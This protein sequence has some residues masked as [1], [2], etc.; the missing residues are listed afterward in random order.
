[1]SMLIGT[2]SIRHLDY[3]GHI[4]YDFARYMAEEGLPGAYMSG[5]GHSWIPFTRRET[6]RMLD[7]FD[8]ERGLS[9]TERSAIEAWLASLP[10]VGYP[11]PGQ[12][13]DGDGPGVELYF[14]W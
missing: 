7:E 13:D 9:A 8:R 6:E 14:S 5:M 2:I 4:A 3:P 1:M 11:P 12:E 10:W